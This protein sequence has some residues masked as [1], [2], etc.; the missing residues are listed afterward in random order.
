MIVL[1][2]VLFSALSYFLIRVAP[3]LELTSVAMICLGIVALLTVRIRN[4]SA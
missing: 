2:A 4:H 3:D 1:A